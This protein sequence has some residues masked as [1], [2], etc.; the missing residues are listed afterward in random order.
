MV[1]INFNRV[2]SCGLCNVE[3]LKYPKYRTIK[4]ALDRLRNLNLHPEAAMQKRT[5]TT[6]IVE[7]TKIFGDSELEIIL[8]QH[9]N[10]PKG[11]LEVEPG[12]G[13]YLTEYTFTETHTN[14][15]TVPD[16]I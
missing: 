4:D 9:F 16:D 10:M 2:Y 11:K 3:Y 8:R 14:A 12:G 15:E 5:I 7:K 13:N 6:T 1:L